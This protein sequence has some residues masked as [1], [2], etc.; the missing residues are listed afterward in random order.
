MQDFM[1]TPYFW[2]ILFIGGIIGAVILAHKR[3]R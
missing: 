3:R 1:N 2:S